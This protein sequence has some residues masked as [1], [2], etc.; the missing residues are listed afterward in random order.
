MRRVLMFV[1]V[2]V[3]VPAMAR[4]N[5]RLLSG[6]IDGK[7][8]NCINQRTIIGQTIVDD[9]TIIFERGGGKYYR[10]TID[11]SCPMLRPDRSLITKQIAVGI[12]SGE[13]FEVFDPVSRINYGACTWGPFV[14]YQR[15]P[16]P[17]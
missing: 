15:P 10:S 9:H 12:C 7:P 13:I 16:R 14:P 3:A 5:P 8:S 1:M 6:E 17:K 2:A 4:E 11:P